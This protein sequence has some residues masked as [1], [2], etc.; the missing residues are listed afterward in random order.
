VYEG[1]PQ[2]RP[3]VRYFF[4]RFP[5]FVDPSAS[6]APPV[7]TFS[8]V[9]SGSASISSFAAHLAA[10][11]ALFRHLGAFRFVYVAPRT[12]PFARAEKRFQSFVKQ[13]LEAD[14]ASEIL[15]YFLIRKKWDRHE[16]VVP[17]TEDFEFLAEAR[18]RFHDERFEGLYHAWLAGAVEEGA[19]R[20]EFSH[21]N[22]G[23]RASFG[24]YLVRN[25]GSPVD[26]VSRRHV[27]TG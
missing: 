3:T 4:D 17:V 23:P 2:S 11:Q 9:D 8:Y 27:N 1:G 10:Y 25:G 7:A 24:T 5:L 19:L 21:L 18:R 6:P 12:A 14:V 15:R 20:A 26:E 16:Y 13:P 22:P